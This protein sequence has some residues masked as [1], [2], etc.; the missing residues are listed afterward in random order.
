MLSNRLD[1]KLYVLTFATYFIQCLVNVLKSLMEYTAKHQ[2][3]PVVTVSELSFAEDPSPAEASISDS[4][5][6]EQKEAKVETQADQVEKA[7]DFKSKMEV[8]VSKVY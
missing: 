7:K 2:P 5:D 3:A 6:L 8:A 4:T 1:Y